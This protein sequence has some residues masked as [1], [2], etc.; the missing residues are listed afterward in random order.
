MSKKSMPGLDGLEEMFQNSTEKRRPPRKWAMPFGFLAASVAG[1]L[2]LAGLVVPAVAP[3]AAAPPI[4][5]AYWDSLPKEL[6]DLPLPQRSIITDTNGAQIAEFYFENRIIVPLAQISPYAVDALLATEDSRFYEHGGV[7]WQGVARAAGNDLMG[8]DL[9]GASTI[10]QQLVKNTLVVHAHDEDAAAAAVEQSF[11]RKIDEMSY[12]RAIEEKYT[13]D[14]I[15][16]KYFNIV[17][18][19]NGVYGIGTAAE[20]YF[21]K[22]PTDLTLAEAA[23][24]IGLLK[25]PS[26]YDPIDH[27]EAAAGRRSV[28]LSRMVTTNKI[29]QAEADAANAEPIAVQANRPPN[30]CGASTYPFFC[31]WVMDSILED[32]AFGT[33]REERQAVLYRGGLTI[34]TTLDP[35]VQDIAQSEVDNALGRENRVAGGIA[36]VQPGTGRVLALAQNRTWGKEEDTSTPELK[37]EIN[38]VVRDAFQTGS[39]FKVFTLAAALESGLPANSIINA[40]DVYNPG[41]MNTPDGGIQNDGRGESGNLSLYEATAKSSNTFYAVLQE[42]VGVLNV[43]DMARNLGLTVPDNVSAKDASFTLGVTDTSPLKMAAAYATFAASGVYCRP[44]GIVSVTGP[45]G[46][47]SAPDPGCRQA[48]SRHTAEAVNDIL[49]QVID[50]PVPSRTGKTASIGRPAAGKTGTTSSHSSAWFAGYT[51][52]YATAVW[53]GDPR[54]GFRYPLSDGL[55]YYGRWTTDVYGAQI[56]APLW[57]NV[58]GRLHEGVEVI[59]LPVSGSGVSADLIIPDVRGL[60]PLDAQSTL[61]A[62]GFKVVFDAALAA[63]NEAIPADVVVAQNPAGGTKTMNPRGTTITLTLSAGS[64]NPPISQE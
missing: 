2:L 31:Q 59:G 23:M 6:P 20:Y 54:G 41:Y 15:L 63:P 49:T 46:P 8:K 38:Y 33:T 26:A 21:G 62:Q 51:P 61:E 5:Q 24:L 4:A 34:Q 11:A 18:Y 9:Q 29:T 12:A 13:K 56:S 22:S 58:M 16:E 39:T 25:N 52:Q 64:V 27:P 36:V 17:L 48:V 40:P 55:R 10:T 42:K 53:L 43:A 50:G 44:V 37:T 7:D 19:S 45:E 57:Q 60:A 28:V 35:R 32:P 1:G 14:E 3:I 47:M 30:G